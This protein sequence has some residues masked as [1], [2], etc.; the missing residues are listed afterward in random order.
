MKKTWMTVL[1]LAAS[2][3][4]SNAYAQR[5]FTGRHGSTASS[6]VTRSGNTLT[7]N[8]TATGARGRSANGTATVKKTATGATGSAT[9]N[10]PKGG[11]STASGTAVKNSNGTTTVSGTATGPRG[12]TGTGSTTVPTH[13]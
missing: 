1:I 2:F 7:A 13:Q 9:V 12:N 5:S 4:F 10:G 11:T 3:G 8:G 6:S